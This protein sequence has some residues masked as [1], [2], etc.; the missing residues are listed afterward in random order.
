M[1]VIRRS[2][3]AHL[4][5]PGRT[6]RVEVVDALSTVGVARQAPRQ[7]ESV[8]VRREAPEPWATAMIKAGATDPRN[9]QRP[10]MSRL[11]EMAGGIGP[12]TITGMIY[13]E[14]R[15][16]VETIRRVADALRVKPE[17]VSEWAGRA[18]AVRKPYEPPDEA[19]LLTDQQRKAL[20]LLIRSIVADR[21]EE[22]DPHGDTATTRQAEGSSV[23]GTTSRGSHGVEGLPPG[24]GVVA[25]RPAHGRSRSR[26][27]GAAGTPGS[28][29]A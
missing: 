16:D 9:A 21:L 5:T 26:G 4:R 15:T 24:S 13:G 25:S 18:R 20:N 28:S 7:G 22:S 27:Q 11:G 10:S 17:L 3:A 14:R 2:S 6:T 23:T 1:R 19:D 29:T 12:S 8:D